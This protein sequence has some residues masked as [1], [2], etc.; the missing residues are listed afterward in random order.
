MPSFVPGVGIPIDKRTKFADVLKDEKRRKDL[1]IEDYHL[2]LVKVVSS[3]TTLLEHDGLANII[4][5]R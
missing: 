4:L 3:L 2:R 5:S 1:K